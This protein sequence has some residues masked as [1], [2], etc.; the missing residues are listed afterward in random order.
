MRHPR[1]GSPSGSRIC[2]HVFSYS[3]LELS[4]N[5]GSRPWAFAPPD[6]S[7]EGVREAVANDR[8]VVQPKNGEEVGSSSD[9]LDHAAVVQES[10]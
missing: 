2:D 5:F 1:A 10:S 9:G 4:V 6:P 7:F 3:S 8:V